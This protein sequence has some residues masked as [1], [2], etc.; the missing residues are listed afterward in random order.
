MMVEA[1]GPPSPASSPSMMPAICSALTCSSLRTNGHSAQC[2]SGCAS[3]NIVRLEVKGYYPEAQQ[4]AAAHNLT[5]P[6]I[7]QTALS[8][9]KVQ[10]CHRK[11]S[12]IERTC[13]LS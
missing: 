7:P 9:L 3:T 10:L 11:W 4:H 2:C 12:S 6:L 1:A 5:Q 8:N 13:C